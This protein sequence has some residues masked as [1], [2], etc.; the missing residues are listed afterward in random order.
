MHLG[1]SQRNRCLLEEGK[2]TKEVAYHSNTPVTDF[3]ICRSCSGVYSSI[4]SSALLFIKL[5]KYV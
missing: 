4:V 5:A 1:S 2:A 3:T